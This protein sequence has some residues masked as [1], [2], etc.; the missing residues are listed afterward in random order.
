MDDRSP[1]SSSFRLTSSPISRLPPELLLKILHFDARAWPAVKQ[2][3]P[4]TFQPRI[5]RWSHYSLVSR[6]WHAVAHP[7]VWRDVM[8]DLNVVVDGCQEPCC[9][10][11]REEDEV[12]GQT[13]FEALVSQPELA[14]LVRRL[15]VR[16]FVHRKG[17]PVNALALN[18]LLDYLPNL[19]GVVFPE[20]Y[21]KAPPTIFS[22]F[23]QLEELTLEGYTG[24]PSFFL[25]HFQ[26]PTFRLTVLTLDGPLSRD[27]LAFLTSSSLTS[28]TSLSFTLSDFR[29][30][31]DL[32]PLLS[33]RTLSV[34]VN[35]SIWAGADYARF[36]PELASSLHRLNAIREMLVS[37]SPLAHLEVLELRLPTIWGYDRASEFAG[38][39]VLIQTIDLRTTL[40]LSMAFLHLSDLPLVVMDVESL[41]QQETSAS[42]APA[43]RGISVES[44]SIREE[45]RLASLAKDRA[46]ELTWSVP[47][48]V[49][50]AEER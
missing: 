39:A 37:A 46:K 44:C 31:Y 35:H 25:D 15:D 22:A 9:A 21:G 3:G 19:N 5:W 50:E 27:E 17:G 42:S 30:S 20:L 6:A 38:S 29:I 4:T 41:L 40:P 1:S 28:L 14:T 43:L 47:D 7:E 32:A 34:T 2:K 18:Y 13:L 16:P 33:L 36:S 23:D 26:P 10:E 24:S 12:V 11:R 48:Y 49:Y 45:E 8:P